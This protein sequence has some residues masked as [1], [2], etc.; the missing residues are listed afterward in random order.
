MLHT[1]ASQT[2]AQAIAHTI[3]SKLSHTDDKIL[4][5]VWGPVS[6]GDTIMGT[7]EHVYDV[8]GPGYV[9]YLDIYPTANLF[10]PV[11]YVYY[12]TTTTDI[13]VFDA[14]SPPRNFHDYQIVDT[15][16]SQ[17]MLSLQNR[18]APIPDTTPPKTSGRDMR[19]AILMNGG[20][21]EYNN[22]IRYWN[23]LSNIYI[24]LTTVYGF[25]DENIIV[26]CSDGTN[27][28]ADQDN[29]QSSPLDLDGDGDPDIMY[30]CVLSN[31]DAV[32]TDLAA[33]LTPSSKLFV[34]TTDHG[35]TAGGWNTVEC[36]WNTEELTDAHF[37][38]LLAQFPE[39]CEILC[40][41]E[42][43]FSGGFL[44]NIVI[45]PG[46]VIG[47]SACRYD[48]YSWA[49]PPDYVYDTYVF[50]W[51]AAMKG[52][53]A[54]GIPVD[55][56][57]ND[58]GKVTFREAYNYAVSMD[59]DDESPQYGEYPD[60]IGDRITLWVSNLPPENLT[61]PIGPDE[62]V[63]GRP[64]TFT[65]SATEPEGEDVYYRFDWGDGTLS[66]WI[67][68]FNSGV[69]GNCTHIWMNESVY[70][71]RAKAKDDVGS[72]TGWSG[73]HVI[74]IHELPVLS[75][76]SITAR[77]GKLDA[78]IKNIGTINVT[79]LNWSIT[80]KGGLILLGKETTATNQRLNVNFCNDLLS[81]FIFG[82]GKTTIT[83]RLETMGEVFERNATASVMLFFI[84]NVQMQ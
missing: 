35:D 40:T 81:R 6:K 73:P 5:Y 51:T 21:D 17:F 33:N 76:E 77:N 50:H 4:A 70:N 11:Q 78:N 22:H 31:V 60:G 42:P 2:D 52:Q 23:D 18:R 43:C 84:K 48:E 47:S 71:V 80:L 74:A 8:P 38:E 7:K 36:L 25:P 27:P 9:L 66:E 75:I 26:L 16:F 46:P 10:H 67:G 57:V 53:D 82:F 58:D 1:A 28:A 15:P 49:M 63:T 39:G 34:F 83:V 64:A 72:E 59:T 12:S 37:E 3:L 24:T 55:A 62:G 68:P 29:G 54:Y 61:V 41:L 19:Y 45:P 56:D 79:D 30:S 14:N 69:P 44:D 32:F 65:T 13:T 20:Y